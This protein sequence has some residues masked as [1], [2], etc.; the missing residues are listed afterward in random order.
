MNL[1]I[2]KLYDASDPGI[3]GA[4]KAGVAKK[5]DYVQLEAALASIE[6]SI[7]N[8]M[9]A[10]SKKIDVTSYSGSAHDNIESTINTIR[11]YLATME[12]PLNKMRSKVAEVKDEYAARE[13][14]IKASL[15]GIGGNIA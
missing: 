11:T 3:G 15:D 10:L 7:N 9:E 4:S 1:K 13:A 14:K 2:R 5:V 8:I 12:E 6:T